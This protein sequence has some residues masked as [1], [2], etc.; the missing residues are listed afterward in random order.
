M[1]IF[2]KKCGIMVYYKVKRGVLMSR[3]DGRRIKGGMPMDAISPFLMPT[4]TGASNTF[5]TT[6]DIDKCEKLIRE[7]RL[8]GM[9]GLGM[10]HI[11]MA[12]YIR[13]VSQ[14]PGINRFIRGQRLYARN[15]I[16]ICMVVKKELKLNSPETVVK[17]Y[18][19][20][21]DTLTG[22]Y[23]NLNDEIEKNRA[24][25]DTNNMDTAARILVSLPRILLRFAVS[26]LK[27]LDYFGLLPRFL[28]KLSPF[29]GSLFITNL[30]SL[31]IPP[32]YHHLYDFGNLPIFIALGAKR[33][34][35]E[36]TK[37]G[38]VIKRRVIDFTVVSDERICDGHYYAT[39]FKKLKKILENPEQLLVPPEHV[40]NDIK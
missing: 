33:T 19:K 38:E 21:D 40:V 8:E 2:D 25:G 17:L 20:P 31:G 29:H 13:V 5:F 3:K 9:T 27:L 4:R 12:S 28:T 37:E 7:K 22:I 6:V 39:A 16:E 32:V 36:T 15:G 1:L 23:N 18:A 35:Y 30:G 14:L 24:E 11:L 26:L 10:I 34:V